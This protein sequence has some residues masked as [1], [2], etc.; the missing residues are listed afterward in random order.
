MICGS[1]YLCSDLNPA[2][3]SSKPGLF[4]TTEFKISKIETF[5][6]IFNDHSSYYTAIIKFGL[7]AIF[8]IFYSGQVFLIGS[9]PQSRIQLI[10]F[11]QALTK[12]L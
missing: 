12:G 3:K 5:L 9:D 7:F 1:G 10:F 4:L 6:L 8:L 11:Q 2:L